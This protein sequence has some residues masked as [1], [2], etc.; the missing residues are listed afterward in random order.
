MNLLLILLSISGL[1]GG[2]FLMNG[3]W[4]EFFPAIMILSACIVSVGKKPLLKI[5][6]IFNIIFGYYVAHSSYLVFA[7]S[8][9]FWEYAVYLKVVEII[10]YLVIL[11]L[12]VQILFRNEVKIWPKKIRIG[13]VTISLIVFILEIVFKR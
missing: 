13:I 5:V 10:L 3:L 12:T 1:I 6:L 9:H 11:F 2:Y 7:F 8:N 4:Y